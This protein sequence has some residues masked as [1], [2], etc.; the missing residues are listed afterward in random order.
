MKQHRKYE[1]PII[2]AC[3]HIAENDLENI[4]EVLHHRC[5]WFVGDPC[6]LY[7]NVAGLFLYA[8]GSVFLELTDKEDRHIA[9]QRALEILHAGESFMIF[10]EGAR[11][12]TEN[13]PVMGLFSGTAKMSIE[14]NTKIVPVAIEQYNHHFIINF[15]DALHPGKYQ[16]AVKMTN[17][18]RD[19]LATLKWEI[20]ENEGIQ[21]RRSYP[22]NYR[23]Q[24]LKEFEDHIQPY[25]TWETV[26][27]SR[28]RTREEAE[29][30]EVIKY[31]DR[32]T[33]QYTV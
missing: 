8:Q 19:V 17:D 28:F 30:N 27:R 5:W 1:E 20:W 15:G 32:I 24:F 13:L 3:T 26:E 18:L 9:Y 7:K 4:Y 25:D 21:F 10:P 12:G 14:T 6:V 16:D 33:R 29:Y 2:Y 23:E 11:N 22:S 31:S